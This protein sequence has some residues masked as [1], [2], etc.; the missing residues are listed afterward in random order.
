MVAG[1]MRALTGWA[2][3]LVAAVAAAAAAT[4]APT[5][6][7]SHRAAYVLSLARALPGS[8]IMEAQGVL[9]YEWSDVCEGWAMQQQFLLKVLRAT[10]DGFAI[11][12]NYVT[13]ESKD[14]RRFRFRTR[15]FDN[16]KLREELVGEAKVLADGAAGTAVFTKPEE[17]EIALP[18]GTLFPTRHTIALLEA[19]ISGK[20]S[21][22][23]VVFDGTAK[24]GAQEI[25]AVVGKHQEPMLDSPF[26]A[27]KEMPSWPFRIAFFNIESVAADPALDLGARYYANGVVDEVVLD[28][29]D[30]SVAAELSRLEAVP[31][32]GC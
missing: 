31:G 16:G 5:S 17:M 8:G 2:V 24:D 21:L 15:H 3:A 29:G 11:A 23:R 6:L 18:A 19:A 28:Y 12:S 1:P 30:F 26:D 13:W 32:V 25:N 14:G 7:L 10:D 27:L 22:S 20:R 4:A 9:V